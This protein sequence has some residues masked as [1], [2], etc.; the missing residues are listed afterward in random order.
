M[1]EKSFGGWGGFVLHV[2]LQKTSAL[3]FTLAFTFLRSFN[4]HNC[5][6]YCLCLCLHYIS[7]PIIH[8][9]FN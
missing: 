6:Q 4:F 5:L 2:G 8:E 7:S 1:G 9:C 3:T